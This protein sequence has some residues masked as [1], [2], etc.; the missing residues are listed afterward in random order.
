MEAKLRELASLLAQRNR[1][2]EAI[3]RLVGRPASPGHI[4]EFIAAAIFGIQLF[5]SATNKGSDGVFTTG[6]LQGRTVNVKLYGKREGTLDIRVDA[7]PDYYLVLTG[8][9]SGPSTS[10]GTTRPMVIQFAYL[11]SG[12]TVL[13]SPSDSGSAS[14]LCVKRQTGRM[15]RRRSMAYSKKSNDPTRSGPDYRT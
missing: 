11:F 5:E 3:A 13:T 9:K 14:Q 15:A 6:P 2:D 10:R 1:L 7:I 8:P 12:P 4:G